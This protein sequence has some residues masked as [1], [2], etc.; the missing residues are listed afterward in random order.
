MAAID[1]VEHLGF[2]EEGDVSDFVFEDQRRTFM[3]HGYA[4]DPS[5]DG[6]TGVSNFIGDVA[7]AQE[8]HGV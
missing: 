1:C 5:V 3:S 2:V 6:A 8:N 4:M 7:R